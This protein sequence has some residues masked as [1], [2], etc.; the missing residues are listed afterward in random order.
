ML[1]NVGMRGGD[2]RHR[3]D[4]A[5]RRQRV[6]ADVTE[7]RLKQQ[8]AANW[9]AELI[10]EIDDGRGDSP[11]LFLAGFCVAGRLAAGR[12]FPLPIDPF[13]ELLLFRREWGRLVFSLR[14]GHDLFLTWE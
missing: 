2:T 14:R 8:S 6:P 1:L 11:S 5:G 9:P 7:W 13:D 10:D 3:R 4:N 12:T